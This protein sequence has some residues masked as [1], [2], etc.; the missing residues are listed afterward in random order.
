MG[1]GAANPGDFGAAALLIH[2]ADGG[3]SHENKGDREDLYGEYVQSFSFVSADHGWAVSLNAAS[4]CNIMEFGGST[5]PAPTP[6]PPTPGSPHYEKPPCQAG[7]KE[8]SIDG[9]DGKL[10]TTPCYASGACPQDK[11]DDVSALPTCALSDSSTGGMYCAL[12][13]I[14]DKMCGQADGAMCNGGICMYNGTATGNQAV[15]TPVKGLM[16]SVV[17]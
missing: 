15:L 11:P 6:A 14:T 9:M 16:P 1:C 12:L 4:T 5:P 3:Q 10:C 17:V 7:E 13:C 2:S 8:V